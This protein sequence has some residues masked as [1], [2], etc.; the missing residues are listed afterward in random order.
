MG[1]PNQK[2]RQKLI[3]AGDVTGYNERAN[4]LCGDLRS[5]VERCVET[6]LLNNVLIR[7][8]RGLQTQGRIG[9]LAK[10]TLEDCA[11]ID[12]LMTQ[13]SVLNIRNL[14]RYLLR[15]LTW[16][17]SKTTLPNWL[18]ELRN[19]QSGRLQHQSSFENRLFRSSVV[20]VQP[21]HLFFIAVCAVRM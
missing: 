13:Y 8:R 7:F 1:C 14:M 4:S 17:K 21:F 6:V 12:D 2:C 11:F 15:L 18:L 3:D 19:S 9:A 10:I 20:D 16:P 5:L